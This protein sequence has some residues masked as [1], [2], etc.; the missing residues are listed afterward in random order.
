MNFRITTVVK[1]LHFDMFFSHEEFKDDKL[2]DKELLNS[3]DAVE[4]RK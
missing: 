4:Q 3:Y 2:V 1:I